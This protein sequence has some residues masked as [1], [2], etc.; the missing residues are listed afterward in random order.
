MIRVVVTSGKGAATPTALPCAV[1][2]TA[3]T[4]TAVL[5]RGDGPCRARQALA[6]CAKAA[7]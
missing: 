1:A 3:A 7:A 4:A 5:L 2:L 6:V